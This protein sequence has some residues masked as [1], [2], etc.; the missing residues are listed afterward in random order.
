MKKARNLERSYD[1]LN[2]RDDQFDLSDA[3]LSIS[4]ALLAVTSLTANR[5]LF[6]FS[7]LFA[8]FGVIMGI[9]GL[10]GFSL[11][12]GWLTRLLS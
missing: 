10:A 1:D 7:W 2:F 3:C 9:A 11:H 6:V 8:G 4:L 12:P 5:R